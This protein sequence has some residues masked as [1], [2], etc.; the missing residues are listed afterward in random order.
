MTGLQPP[1]F[2][3]TGNILLKKPFGSG[4]GSMAFFCRSSSTSL[5][6]TCFSSPR[7]L[8]WWGGLSGEIEVN[9]NLS[10]CTTW[11]IQVLSVRDLHA[12]KWSCRRPPTG[13]ITTVGGVDAFWFIVEGMVLISACLVVSISLVGR[14]VLSSEDWTGV[15]C[16]T[17]DQIEIFLCYLGPPCK[18]GRGQDEG[19]GPLHPTCQ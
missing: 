1:S 3:G 12:C 18:G 14:G 10:P 16:G 13:A 11:C 15:P 9:S 6:I 5:V 17:V 19:L 4:A 8:G 2:L 7:I